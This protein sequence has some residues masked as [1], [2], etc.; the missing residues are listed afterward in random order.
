[1]YTVIDRLSIYNLDGEESGL[2]YK[3][4]SNEV[5]EKDSG[6]QF[7]H[8]IISISIMSCLADTSFN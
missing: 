1:M 8:T 2:C 3:F 4:E 7:L 5:N 6:T